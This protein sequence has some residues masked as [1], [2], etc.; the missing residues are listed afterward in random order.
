MSAAEQQSSEI[1][2]I[3]GDA[4]YPEGDGLKIIVHVCNN[5][6]GW[7]KGFVLALSDRWKRPELAYREWYERNG[8]T[9]FR[10][11]MGA[12]QFVPVTNDI[13]VANVIG[14][15]GLRAKEGKPPV[16]YE[17]ISK[18]LGFVAAYAKN[19]PEKEV[20]VHMPR[21]GCGLAGGRWE[22][23]E[24]LLIQHFAEAGIPITVYDLP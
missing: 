10:R 14:Q 20:S 17:A 6:G 23:I 9:K 22:E 5:R 1:H 16:R 18:G 4:V 13:S 12:M 21:I 7:G 3:T 8:D 11:M 2:Y 24:P 15:D 19:N